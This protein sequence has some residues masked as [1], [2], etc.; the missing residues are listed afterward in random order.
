MMQFHLGDG[1]P[2]KRQRIS[3]Q[4]MRPSSRADIVDRLRLRKSL[5]SEQRMG[6]PQRGS[7][8]QLLV[9]TSLSHVGKRMLGI[10]PFPHGHECISKP[11]QSPIAVEGKIDG[12]GHGV[13]VKRLC[14]LKRALLEIQIPDPPFCPPSV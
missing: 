6:Q 2:L 11:Q 7:L 5:L 14:F 10:A 12:M 8:E 1:V 13:L 3:P 4:E 9:L